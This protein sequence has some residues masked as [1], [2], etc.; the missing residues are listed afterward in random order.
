MAR[1]WTTTSSDCRAAAETGCEAG[2][3]MGGS[4]A[5]DRGLAPGVRVSQPPASYEEGVQGPVVR[6]RRR[7]TASLLLAGVGL[8]A[9]LLGP[10]ALA[11]PVVLVLLA[12]HMPGETI[13]RR[14]LFALACLFGLNAAVLTVCAVSGVPVDAR[15]LFGGYLLVLALLPPASGAPA[16]ATASRSL[17]RWAAGT[18]LLVFA[19][20]YRVFVTATTGRTAAVLTYSTDGA[21]HLQLVQAI[22]R[23]RGYINLAPQL[24]GVEAGLENYPGGWA[25][26]V[27]MFVQLLV[28]TTADHATFLRVVAPMI[29]ASFALMVYFATAAALEAARG[30]V[31]ELNQVA[32][33]LAA[34]CIAVSAVLGSTAFLQVSSSYAQIAGT[35]AILA[36]LLLLMTAGSDR[37]RDLLVLGTLAVATAHTWYL[38]AP[39]FG[40]IVLQFVEQQRPP[41]WQLAAIG[42][43]T[44]LLTAYPVVTGPGAGSQLS[45]PGGPPVL[46]L[47]GVSMLLTA[48]L[49]AAWI[50][51]RP[52][53]PGRSHR[54]ALA[55]PLVTSLLLVSVVLC[56]QELSG[57]GENY[58]AIK[59]LYTT[60]LFAVIAGASVVAMA[61]A[62]WTRDREFSTTAVA[63][64]VIVVALA[65]SAFAIR[66]MTFPYFLGQPPRDVEESALSAIFTTHPGG[67]GE[68]EEV[69]VVGCSRR[70]DRRTMQW[71]YDLALR[72]SPSFQASY[73]RFAW[74]DSSD[75]SMLVERARAMPA[76]RLEIYTARRCA[77][78]GLSEL[79]ALPNVSVVYV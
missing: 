1:H 75:V 2:L 35:T 30:V 44:G 71:P 3:S 14:L 23:Q 41:R 72:W 34:A 51:L 46:T 18:A 37:L 12:A 19:L 31:G 50:L 77:P 74:A 54:L 32:C 78:A 10:S 43:P 68:H 67:L 52:G 28:G 16:T 60:F 20:F 24:P 61:S 79:N 22:L 6:A 56:L 17:D 39:V 5:A 4:V 59:V 29:V 40:V 53:S 33:G 13:V 76:Q 36:G 49:A 62:R 15:W 45:Q 57:S 26:S 8:T 38:L 48:T 47:V 9:L 7:R 70:G 58:Y 55:T 25:G 21:T 69:W 66:N 11:I 42:L 73:D 64:L 63:S 27:A 65:T